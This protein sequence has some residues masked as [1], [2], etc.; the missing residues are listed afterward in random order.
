MRMCRKNVCICQV[1]LPFGNGIDELARSVLDDGSLSLKHSGIDHD[2]MKR[3]KPS[4]P[5]KEE[6][7]K[8]QQLYF[9]YPFS[10]IFPVN[11]NF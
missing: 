10:V 1:P 4:R 8:S 9:S 7:L 11:S 3:A 6:P 5:L 2:A